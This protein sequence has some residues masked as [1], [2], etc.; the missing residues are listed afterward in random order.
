ME[1]GILKG[2][3]IF[4]GLALASLVFLC[5]VWRSGLETVLR[6]GLCVAPG[7]SFCSSVSPALVCL[8]PGVQSWTGSSTWR[9]TS[10]SGKWD[11][12]CPFTNEIMDVKRLSNM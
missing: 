11:N 7:P 12:T 8:L 9:L 1:L 10:S 6:G 3:H 5:P 2:V 4:S